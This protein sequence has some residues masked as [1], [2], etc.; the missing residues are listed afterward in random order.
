MRLKL[1]IRAQKEKEQKEQEVREKAERRLRNM[2][3]LK[4]KAKAV[5]SNVLRKLKSKNKAASS[6]NLSVTID[7]KP[8]NLVS[9]SIPA[10]TPPPIGGTEQAQDETKS[11]K[12]EPNDT[13]RPGVLIT[14][15]QAKEARAK[16]Q[17]M[18]AWTMSA[19]VKAR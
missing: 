5:K 11:I 15:D 13:I 10:V 4:L 17:L 6:K 18:N 14:E 2:A 12:H 19:Y 7:D 3:K 9:L 16:L 1:E 8:V